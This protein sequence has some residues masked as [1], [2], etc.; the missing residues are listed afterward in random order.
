M[1]T[2]L[3]KGA[4]IRRI[5]PS[6]VHDCRKT[7][8]LVATLDNKLGVPM[9]KLRPLGTR[10]EITIALDVVYHMAIQREID[11]RRAAKIKKKG[12]K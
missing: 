11:I 4:S 9:L 1:A 3:R 12:A 10:Q 5:V 7:G 2:R 8:E 6:Q